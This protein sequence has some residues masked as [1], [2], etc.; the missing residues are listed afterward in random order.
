MMESA[1]APANSFV[2]SRLAIPSAGRGEVIA[3]RDADLDGDVDLI[4]ESNVQSTTSSTAFEYWIN[5]GD[6]A[7]VLAVGPNQHV[8]PSGAT[9]AVDLDADGDL[10]FLTIT[11]FA[12]G[13]A[14]NNED[15]GFSTSSLLTY[16]AIQDSAAADMD[17]DGDTDIVVVAG[18][19]GFQQQP[20][21]LL[22]DAS[23]EF[24]DATGRFPLLTQVGVEVILEDFNG[25]GR[26]D[27]LCAGD[28]TLLLAQRPSGQFL[29]PSNAQIGSTQHLAAADFDGNGTLD[30]LVQREIFGNLELLANPGNG[31]FVLGP[32]QP[33]GPAPELVLDI[34]A[35][36]L[37]GDGDTDA[38]V[39]DRG[40]LLAWLNDGS[41][42]LTRVATPVFTFPDE[43]I[44]RVAPADLDDDGDDD[45]LV[46]T[47]TT[48][49]PGTT[50]FTHVLRNDGPLSYAFVG[51]FEGTA[52][53]LA[54]DLDG[55][56]DPDLILPTQTLHNRQRHVVR[57][58]VLR[59]GG[60]ASF[61][62]HVIPTPG[63]STAVVAPILALGEAPSPVLTPSGTFFLDPGTLA[64]LPPLTTGADDIA[65]LGFEIPD[66]AA[67]VGVPISLQGIAVRA[68]GQVRL[69]N[70][71]T[72]TIVR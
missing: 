28:P 47:S 57:R 33:A 36:D 1:L 8:V 42:A 34:A 72:Q 41:G 37:D 11:P 44:L 52:D 58:L 45:L 54:V 21:L 46:G 49:F 2:T 43:T 70:V 68:G 9:D 50:E 13:I 55:D 56:L 29:V 51:T 3:L 5:P 66:A 31:G 18:Q 71:V 12:A 7:F 26:R 30:L 63:T 40:N 32:T 69:T 23:G 38:L 61:D 15:D 4:V 25:D 53:A 65:T 22:Q 60:P 6:G 27:A 59:A 24:T 16:T 67:L 62:F 17:G 48:V 14:R 39:A 35:C 10:D 64:F 19:P 20:R